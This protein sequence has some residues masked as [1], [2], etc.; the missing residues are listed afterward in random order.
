MRWPTTRAVISAAAPA[1]NPTTTRTGR[2]GYSSAD[3]GIANPAEQASA[4]HKAND[5]AAG[6]GFLMACA[7]VHADASRPRLRCFSRITHFSTPVI[8]VLGMQC[9]AAFDPLQAGS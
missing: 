2:V 5:K 8:L 9:P 1:G 6:P 3:A 7:L 4:A